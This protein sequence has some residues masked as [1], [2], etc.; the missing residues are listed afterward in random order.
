MQH[1]RAPG[2]DL[3]PPPQDLDTEDCW[4]QEGSRYSHGGEGHWGTHKIF[5]LLSEGGAISQPT[6]KKAKR[7]KTRKD[8]QVGGC[9]WGAVIQGRGLLFVAGREGDAAGD[10]VPGQGC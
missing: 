9:G 3:Q 8:E 1:D 10:G 7:E 5:G 6:T 2:G 4:Y